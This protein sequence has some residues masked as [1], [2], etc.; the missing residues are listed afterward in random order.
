L[1]VGSPGSDGAVPAGSPA[2]VEAALGAV[3]ALFP[4]RLF[5]DALPPL[6]LRHQLY[7]V[8]P[9]RTAV[10]RHL[11]RLRDE[12]R[13]RLLHLGLGPDA[14]AVVSLPLY[15][16]KALAAVAGSPREPLV[17]RF[18]EAA[19]A[20]SPEL[21]YEQR[22]MREMGFGD[23]D[24]TQLVAAGLLTVRDAGS[25]WLAVPGAG[26]SIGA[27]QAPPG[28]AVP[29]A[30]PGGRGQSKA[31]PNL[32]PGPYGSY[33]GPR[34]GAAPGS[35]TAPAH[36]GPDTPSRDPMD[37]IGDPMDPIGDPARPRHAIPRSY[38]SY[39]GSY[40]SYRGS[41]TAPTHRSGILWIL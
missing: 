2:A 36:A 41:S 12:G 4:R 17:R 16:E 13:V 5:G 7:S 39:R 21:S 31:G 30:A 32:R 11:N 23:S 27:A 38:G 22:S 8:L 14:L 37:P 3:A 10:D 34:P 18:L 40:G 28:G 20:T 33:R 6:L 25:W 19:V 26:G 24:I 9:D 35:G 15:R 29:C 1:P